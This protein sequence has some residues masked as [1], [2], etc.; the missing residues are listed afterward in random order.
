MSDG[1]IMLST[2]RLDYSAI[3]GWRR[4][5]L[6]AGVRRAVRIIVNV[7]EWVHR[8]DAVRG[9]DADRGR[10]TRARYSELGVIAF[11]R[12]LEVGWNSAEPPAS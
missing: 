10:R 8:A 11:K 5:D 2:D 7:E 1:K 4:V 6:P 12:R 3:A 9:A